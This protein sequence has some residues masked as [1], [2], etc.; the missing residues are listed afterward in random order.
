MSESVKG[1]RSAAFY[2]SL[3]GGAKRAPVA[4][5]DAAGQ[6][7][8]TVYVRGEVAGDDDEAAL[9]NAQPLAD[10]SVMNSHE[11]E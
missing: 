9:D 3:T 2:I 5:Y 7:V 4:V 1:K 10:E 11:F 6:Y 8:A